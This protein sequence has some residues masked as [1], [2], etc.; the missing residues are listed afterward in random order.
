MLVGFMDGVPF[1]VSRDYVK[2]F[3]NF[4][5]SGEGR[6]TQHDIIGSKPVLEFLGGDTEKISITMLL[7]RDQGIIPEVELNNLRRMRDKGKAFPLVIGGQP[8]GENLWIL[9]SIDESVNY[10]GGMG[11]VLSVSVSVTLKEYVQ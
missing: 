2:T 5:R 9:E 6:W 8:V 1:L 3:D 11:T 7:R 4:A 10:W